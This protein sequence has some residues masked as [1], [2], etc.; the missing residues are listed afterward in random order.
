MAA[1]TLPAT[2]ASTPA[3]ATQAPAAPT[4]EPAIRRFGALPLAAVLGGAAQVALMAGLLGAYLAFRHVTSP[5]PPEGVVIDGYVGN[6]I[7]VTALMQSC[8]VQWAVRSARIDDQ[9]DLNIA[10]LLAIAFGAAL[11][12][13]VWYAMSNAGF[14]VADGTY[15]VVYYA[16]HGTMLASLLVGIGVLVVT[17]ARSMGG[18]FGPERRESVLAAAIHWHAQVVT[19]LLVWAVV[20]VQK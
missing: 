15:G 11:A 3:P 8:T 1:T 10:L 9:R 5:W 16:I 6:I 12:N 18:H 7:S 19:W 20:W 17:L 4:V 14:G 13:G 2:R